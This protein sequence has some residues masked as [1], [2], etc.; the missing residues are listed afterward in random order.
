MNQLF[1]AVAKLVLYLWYNECR[2]KYFTF[3]AQF[4]RSLAAAL[5]PVSTWMGDRLKICEFF[6]H[7]FLDFSSFQAFSFDFRSYEYIRIIK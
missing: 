5:S 4:F 1:S 2:N 7:F 3:Y 6:F